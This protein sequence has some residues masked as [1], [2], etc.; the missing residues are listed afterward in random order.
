MDDDPIARHLRNGPPKDPRFEP[1]GRW[2]AMAERELAE[3]PAASR[4]RGATLFAGLAAAAVFLVLVV[5]GGQLLQFRD[6]GFG[7]LVTE[8][9]SRGALRVAIDG[10]PPQAF[11]PARGYEGF[12]LDIAREVAE[13]LGVRLDVAV[14]PRSELLAA[15]ARGQW[16]LALSSISA[17]LGHASPARATD[18]YAVVA[19]AVV[20]GVDDQANRLSE[21]GSD[22]ACVVAG[23]SAEAW[24]QGDL[25]ATPD[26]TIQP[27][28][29]GIEVHV[30]PTLTE[31]LGGVADG[32]WRAVVVDRPSDV[33]G[34][35]DVRV[36]DVAPFEL[37]LVALLDGGKAGV[38]PLVARLNVLFAAMA[39][40]G[41]IAD[42]SR[43]RFAG[44]DVT[45]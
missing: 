34:D 3:A 28:P 42:I 19:G 12:D 26:D 6:Q 4:S 9:E 13:R 20:V 23:S 45:P 16:D 15:D 33:V 22:R 38:D 17:A 2:L 27:V 10:G 1:S 25:T 37:S 14:I 41:T 29:A 8:I 11:T 35:G 24:L 40:D 44:A 5:I 31:C 7:G 36:L 32:S 43:R 18:P 30:Q 21:L 39:E